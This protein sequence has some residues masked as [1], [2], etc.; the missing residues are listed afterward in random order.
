MVIKLMVINKDWIIIINIYLVIILI[1]F[2]M[3]Y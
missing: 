2:V 3:E 1:K